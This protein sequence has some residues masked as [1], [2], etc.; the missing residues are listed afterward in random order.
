MFLNEDSLAQEIAINEMCLS[1][2]Y[3]SHISYI[4]NIDISSKNDVVF[5]TGVQDECI[6]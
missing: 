1:R 6:F 2:V 4:N 5:T 3:K